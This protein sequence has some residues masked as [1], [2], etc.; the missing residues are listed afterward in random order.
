MRINGDIVLKG[1]HWEQLR[2]ALIEKSGIFTRVVDFF[3][4]AASIGI[5]SDS[6]EDAQGDDV[7][8]I[9][10]DTYQTNYDLLDIFDFMLKNIILTS[11]HIDFD[12]EERMKIAFDDDYYVDNFSFNTMLVRFANYGANKMLEICTEHDM[13]TMDQLVELIKKYIDDNYRD[14]IDDFSPFDI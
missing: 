10:R 14:R 5:A 2:S 3:V 12:I 1:T 11:N 9:A 7:I 8:T 6:L 4:I 13:D